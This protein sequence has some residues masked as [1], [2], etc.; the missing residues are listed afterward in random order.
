MHTKKTKIEPA[1][2]SAITWPRHMC[3]K[4]GHVT[5]HSYREWSL[6]VV[7]CLT[8]RAV[9]LSSFDVVTSYEFESPM[10]LSSASTAAMW[11]AWI[12]PSTARRT[13]PADRCDAVPIVGSGACSVIEPP[14]VPAI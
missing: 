3:P 4:K 13:L 12:A 10:G 5:S 7:H 14:L 8:S 2:Q 9:V 6:L 11:I 1:A